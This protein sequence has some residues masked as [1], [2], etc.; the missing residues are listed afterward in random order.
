MTRE[1]LNVLDELLDTFEAEYYPVTKIG[2]Q[3]RVVYNA[4]SDLS[5]AIRLAINEK[6]AQEA[7]D[8]GEKMR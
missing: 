8:D 1:D 6:V 4:I 7:Q 5:D 2:D 3:D